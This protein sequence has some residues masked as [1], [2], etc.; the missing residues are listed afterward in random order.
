[1]PPKLPP[2]K[3]IKHQSDWQECLR[4]LAQAPQIAIDL[5]ANG[6]FAYREQMCLIQISTRD[7][8]YIV[9]PFAKLDLEPL[10]VLIADPTIE[11][12]LHAAEYDLILM[13]RDMDWEISNLF[14][15]MWAARILGIKRI[16]L[17]NVLE[18]Y[19]DVT[20]NKKYQR[21]D[22]SKRPLDQAQLAYAQADTAYLLALRDILGKELVDGGHAEESAD[23]FAAQSRVRLPDTDFNSESFW[24]INGIENLTP[25]QKGILRALNIYRDEEA[26]KRDRPPF[27]VFSN[28]ALIEI[29]RTEPRSIGDLRNIEHFSAWQAQ[30][31]GRQILRLVALGKQQPPPKRKRRERRPDDIMARYDSLRNWR[32]ERANKRNV[33]SDVIVSRDSL[34]E[35][36]TVNPQTETELAELDTLGPWQCK[37]YGPEILAILHDS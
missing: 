9:D 11:K 2:Y 31:Y 20:L 4:D 28:R 26:S 7:Q 21:A 1:M 18:T 36:A 35:I 10:G 13:K 8:D 27:K 32:K 14:D 23:I 24:S 22:W 33:A 16:G 17:A 12:V 25:Q 19:F 37:T 29:A 15:T 3:H 6:M 5:E 34:W 30:R